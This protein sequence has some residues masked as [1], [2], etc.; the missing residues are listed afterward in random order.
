MLESTHSTHFHSPEDPPRRTILRYLQSPWQY[1]VLSSAIVCDISYIKLYPDFPPVLVVICTTL[2]SQI[3]HVMPWNCKLRLCTAKF[4]FSVSIRGNPKPT[5][6]MPLSPLSLRQHHS[7]QSRPIWNGVQRDKMTFDVAYPF[8]LRVS[9][10]AYKCLIVMDISWTKV[11]LFIW[12][13]I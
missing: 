10:S 7:N 5:D 11:N 2:E 6:S 12:D 1:N 13:P 9:W 4:S 8:L 3:I